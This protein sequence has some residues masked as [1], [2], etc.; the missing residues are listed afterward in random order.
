MV[1][2]TLA[3]FLSNAVVTFVYDASDGCLESLAIDPKPNSAKSGLDAS[4]ITVQTV[5]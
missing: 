4:W 1:T 3:D 2:F 5:S